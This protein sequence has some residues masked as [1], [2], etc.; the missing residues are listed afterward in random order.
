MNRPE[1]DSMSEI[2]LSAMLDGECDADETRRMLDATGASPAL[3]RRWSR[4]CLVHDALRG[5]RVRSIDD[6]FCAGVMSALEGIDPEFSNAPKLVRRV[7]RRRSYWRPL[8]GLAAAA[9]VAAVLGFGLQAWL[10]PQ[11]STS[12]ASAS[13]T[14]MPPLPAQLA[15]APPATTVSAEPEE[16]RWSQLDADTA[17]QLNEYLLDHSNLR[18]AQGMG[19]ALSYARMTARPVEY[20]QGA[21]H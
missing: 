1:L 8:A 20:R 7:G 6:A 9:S 12:L 5:V 11:A 2:L 19:G 3:Q 15:S 10:N 18:A 4:L 17:R 14:P 16:T 13:S 21:S